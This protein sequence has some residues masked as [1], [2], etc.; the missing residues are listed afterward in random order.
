[1]VSFVNAYTFGP[2]HTPKFTINRDAVSS[3]SIDAYLKDEKPQPGC[4]WN[5]R[6]TEIDE[7]IIDWLENN[8]E[9]SWFLNMCG[10]EID[11]ENNEDTWRFLEWLEEY[12]MIDG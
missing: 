7:A 9:G 8:A 10:R 5:S 3:V 1:M 4:D 6:N 12:E 2:D 11:F